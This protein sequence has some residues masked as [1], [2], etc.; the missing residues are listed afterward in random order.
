MLLFHVSLL[1]FCN[2][3]FWRKWLCFLLVNLGI[4]VFLESTSLHLEAPSECTGPRSDVVQAH[5]LSGPGKTR[6]FSLRHP[7]DVAW[8]STISD[9][10]AIAGVSVVCVTAKNGST[11]STDPLLWFQN[12]KKGKAA[13]CDCSWYTVPADLTSSLHSWQSNFCCHKYVI[14]KKGKAIGHNQP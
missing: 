14:K 1:K 6:G 11:T 9:S 2:S 7:V 12:T 13:S 8:D 5:C 10:S 4:L 3:V